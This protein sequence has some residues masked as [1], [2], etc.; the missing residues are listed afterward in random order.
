VIR[1]AEAIRYQL[2][3][4]RKTVSL[5]RPK[6]AAREIQQEVNRK[7]RAHPKRGKERGAMQ[8]GA[9]RYP[10]PTIPGQHLEKPGNEARA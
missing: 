6:R 3:P 10:E 4:L 2:P 1:N 7:E 5:R 8:A 9:R